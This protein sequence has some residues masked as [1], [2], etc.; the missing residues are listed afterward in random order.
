MNLKEYFEKAKGMGVLATADS[1]G[2]VNTAIYARP[3]VGK[4]LNLAFIMTERRT[5]A[6]VC[7]NPHAS[8]LFR[9]DGVQVAGVR[10]ILRKTVEEKDTDRIKELMRRS[11]STED[12]DNLHLVHFSVEEVRP[13]VSSGKCPV[14]L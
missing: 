14:E 3:H 7:Q 9:E 13:L 10:L 11:Y 2:R 5:Y 8:Y 6:N 4:D 1:S 12:V